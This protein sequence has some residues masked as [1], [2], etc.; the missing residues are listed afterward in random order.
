MMEFHGS[1]GVVEDSTS[2]VDAENKCELNE[3]IFFFSIR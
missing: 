3:C 2:V 1:I